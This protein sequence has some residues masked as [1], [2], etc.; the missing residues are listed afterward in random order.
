MSDVTV[1]IRGLDE[2]EKKLR[3]ETKRVAVK[4][5]RSAARMAGQIWTD[6]IEARAPRDTG[7]LAEHIGSKTRATGG[8]ERNLH[9]TVG[10]TSGERK[11]GKNTQ[12]GKPFYALF[13]ECGT[14][15][16]KHKQPARP[17]MRPA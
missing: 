15:G 11:K 6:A 9:L 5:V 14:Q 16:D 17:F 10:F 7:F 12:V 4:V 2:L 1:E 8:N 13:Q 3:E